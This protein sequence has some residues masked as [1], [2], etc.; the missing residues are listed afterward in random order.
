MKII[1]S[2]L[3]SISFIF[4]A[5]LFAVD[6][7]YPTGQGDK[8]QDLRSRTPD[9]Q[10]LERRVQELEQTLEETR[11]AQNAPPKKAMAE[12][13]EDLL[14][15]VK[16]NGAFWFNYRVQDYDD[17]NK[18]KMGNMG[19]TMFWLGFDVSHK[20]WSLSTR[21]RWY[22]YTDILQYGWVGYEW[23]NSEIQF[24]LTKVPFGILP[25]ASNNYWFGLTYYTGFN[26]Q[27]DMGI[28]WITDINDNLNLQLGFFK[29]GDMGSAGSLNRYSYDIVTAEGE[30][31][32]NEKTNQ[33]NA[34]LAY[35][36][37]N[38]TEVGLSAQYGQLYNNSTEDTGDHWAGG[39]HLTGKY[40]NF[41]V[42]LQAMQYRFNP[43]NPVGV[44]DKVVMIGA[45]EDAFPL[46]SEGQLLEANLAYNMPIN[47]GLIDS[48]KCYNDYTIFM[49]SEEMFEDSQMNTI[50]CSLASGPIFAYLD[51]IIGKNSPYIGVPSGVAFA[52][53][54]NDASWHTMVNLNIGYYF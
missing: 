24:G 12:E 25:Y 47:N 37:G 43:E 7:L 1:I 3:F 18:D 19:D 16:M 4:P 46:A 45:F 52:G 48:V 22:T 41:E 28:K 53:G 51:F 42:Q 13:E 35:Q 44:D 23:D 30:R 20:G 54:E 32:Q 5:T 34:R 2:L 31:A 15:L 29:N 10:Q 40:D 8:L 9:I 50:G 49:K 39:L 36:I 6:D 38:T 17:A 26:D 14:S 33:I 27:N 11:R 21:Y